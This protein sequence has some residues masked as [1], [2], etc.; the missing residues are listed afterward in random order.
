MSSLESSSVWQ[1]VA[2]PRYDRLKHSGRFDVVVVGGGI[3]GLSAAYFLKSA[4]KKVCLLERDRLGSG[5]T[6]QTTAHLTCVTDTPLSELVRTFGR[7]R[8]A[9]A[10]YA[11]NA[12]IDL[13][14]RIAIDHGIACEFRRT[15]SYLHAALEGTADETSSLQAEA[16]LAHELGLDVEFVENVPVVNKPGLRVRDQAKFHPR[17]YLAGL[18]RLV[19]GQGSA[20]HE[21]SEVSRLEAEPLGAI[22]GD[23]R[24]DC[25]FIVIATEVPLTGI[26]GLVKA[27]LLQSRLAAYSTY[28]VSG[29]LPPGQAPDVS[30]WDTGN[31]YYYLRID[32]GRQF[33]RVIFGGKDHKTGQAADTESRYQ[34]LTAVLRGLLPAVAIDHRWSGQVIHTNDGL[35]LIGTT[36]PEQFVATGFDGNGITFGTL[37]GM[38]ARDALLGRK[39]PW[40]EL[41]SVDRRQVRGGTWDYIKENLDFPYYLIADRVASRR[42]SP[43][44]VEPGEGVVFKHEGRHVA[45]ARDAAGQLHAVSAVCPHLGCLVRFNA[46]EQ[47]WDCPCH[48]SR[49]ELDGKLMAGPAESGLDPVTVELPLTLTEDAPAD[50]ATSSSDTAQ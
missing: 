45:C 13:I 27:S 32:T 34:E 11:G 26:N 47:T 37:A 25:D 17:A 44:D 5:D 23:L 22:V 46:A 35:P 15:S 49:F 10:W 41:F 30:L 1:Q 2:L 19:D 50:P 9:L 31:P 36:V 38:M 18:A 12:A 6:G 21:M 20:I 33:D 39:N 28:V 14:E 16:E 3:T 48:G 4:G 24:I 29:K 42:T 40:Q 7:D 8:A 43:G